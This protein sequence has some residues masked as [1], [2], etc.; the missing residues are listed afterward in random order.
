MV[1]SLWSMTT[2]N[3]YIRV[4]VNILGR[5]LYI[6]TARGLGSSYQEVRIIAFSNWLLNSNV[7]YIFHPYCDIIDQDS[8]DVFD[9]Q[10]GQVLLNQLTFELKLNLNLHILEIIFPYDVA[11]CHNVY[12]VVFFT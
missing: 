4:Q 7:S 5:H 10:I 9:I 11:K 8:M 3:L 2:L 6:D 1:L 12:G